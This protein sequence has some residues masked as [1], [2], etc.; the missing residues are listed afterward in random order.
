MWQEEIAAPPRCA[1]NDIRAVSVGGVSGAGGKGVCKRWQGKRGRNGRISPAGESSLLALMT[2][3][4]WLRI[5]NY[6]GE[7]LDVNR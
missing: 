5:E 4:S 6:L 7:T 1:G 2:L 3:T